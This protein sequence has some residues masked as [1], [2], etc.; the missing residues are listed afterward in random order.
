MVEKVTEWK[1]RFPEGR[2]TVEDLRYDEGK[3]LAIKVDRPENDAEYL[4]RLE[5]ERQHT[6]AQDERER[7]EYERLK[8]KFGG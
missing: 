3:Y 1:E 6:A 7:Q 5:R 2:M 8:A 4:A